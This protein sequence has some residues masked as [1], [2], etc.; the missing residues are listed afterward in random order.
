MDNGSFCDKSL[1]PWYVALGVMTVVLIGW[2]ILQREEFMFSN[3]N[4]P[5]S[6]RQPV[7]PIQPLRGEPVFPGPIRQAAMT[8][9]FPAK[10]FGVAALTKATPHGGF[11]LVA[12]TAHM[13]FQES[14][15]D[16]VNDVLP[17]VCD[18]HATWIRRSPVS[19]SPRAAANSDLLFLPPFDGTIDKF[20]RN[21]GYENIGGGVIVDS[22]GYVLTNYHVVQD[23]TD[24]IVTVPG[25][26]SRDYSAKHVAH[27]IQKDL[28]LLKIDSN[29]LFP[30]ARIGDSSFVT[31]GEYVIAMGS[32]FGMEQTVTSG[33][34]SGIRK[35]IR[36]NG[37]RY[38]NMFQTDA[39]INRGSSG[40]PLVNLSGEVIGITTAIYA[41]TGVFNG[42]GFVIPINDAK[43]FLSTNL[44]RTYSRTLDTKGA[45]T[46]KPNVQTN[47]ASQALPVRFGIEA[48]DLDPVM[49]K[50]LG[51]QGSSGVLVNKITIGSPAN[52]AGIERG[53]IITFIAGLPIN[54]IDDIP[55]IASNFKAGDNV[56][57]RIVRNGRTDE[58]LLRVI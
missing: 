56:N 16:A 31:I 23:A 53:D 3:E 30:E 21:K 51:S 24:I 36:I 41:P 7:Q 14:L 5:R 18:I 35:S 17:S 42:T 12:N 9:P 25:L 8:N 10:N 19:P 50:T 4:E 29:D 54:N 38:K 26:P 6:V 40:G 52:L 57:M 1:K 45:L 32:P 37:V 46:N 34:I 33:I 58:I 49:A 27:D 15:T 48:I 47:T 22:R 11:Q 28:A 13:G 44:N 55:A 2:V 20:I 39:P 43:D